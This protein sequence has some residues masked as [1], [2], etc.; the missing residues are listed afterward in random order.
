MPMKSN[1]MQV[2]LTDQDPRNAAR[3]LNALNQEYVVPA[4]ALKK[5]S[6]TEFSKILSRQLDFAET[7]LREAESAL[8]NFK[9]QTITLPSEGGPIT[10]GVAESRLTVMNAYFQKK[11][12][13]DNLKHDTEA[14]ETSLSPLESAKLIS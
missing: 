3:V 13:A 12:D 1:F 4:G 6:L 5:S 8:E 14:L 2:T 7:S 9:I 11:L 10:P